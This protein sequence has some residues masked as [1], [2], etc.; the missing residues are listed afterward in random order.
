MVPPAVQAVATRARAEASTWKGE[1]PPVVDDEGPDSLEEVAVHARDGAMRTKDFATTTVETARSTDWRQSSAM[2]T[3]FSTLTPGAGQFYNGELTKGVFFVGTTYSTLGAASFAHA[4][5]TANGLG[6][7][8]ITLLSMTDEGLAFN[9]SLT[10]PSPITL[11]GWGLYGWSISQAYYYHHPQITTRPRQGVT[12][13]TETSWDESFWTPATAGIAADLM[14]GNGFSVGLDRTGVTTAQYD[15][16]SV[17]VFSAG[18]RVMVGVDHWEH[19]RPGVFVAS[20]L[21]AGQT[22]DDQN[23][24][25]M[26]LGA[27]GTV[28][29]YLS[30]RYYVNYEARY[31]IDG[32]EGGFVQGGGVG[33]HLGG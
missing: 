17:R 31:E 27:G 5:M 21:R 29:Y 30:P 8:G 20:G 14:L 19:L 1:A 2:A 23:S 11:V 33:I 16:T 32:G 15:D 12:L 24:V 22:R 18:G 13:A 25:R 26:V 4:T 28:R 3:G 6:T 7:P 9:G 10:G